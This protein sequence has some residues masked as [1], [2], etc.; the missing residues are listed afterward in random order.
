MLWFY[1]NFVQGMGLVY[2]IMI[3]KNRIP[4]LTF[5]Y[6]SYSPVCCCGLVANILRDTEDLVSVPGT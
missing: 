2:L 6:I 3:L 1:A 4:G 5:L